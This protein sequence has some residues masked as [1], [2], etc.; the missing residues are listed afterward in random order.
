MS[1][2][3]S[4]PIRALRAGDRFLLPRLDSAYDWYVVT[5]EFDPAAGE[6]RATGQEGVE[7]LDLEPDFEVLV[8]LPDDVDEFTITITPWPSLSG[9]DPAALA[10]QIDQTYGPDLE[11]AVYARDR[12]VDAA[13]RDLIWEQ[14]PIIGSE[15][16]VPREAADRVETLA[17]R[18][19]LLMV[20]LVIALGLQEF[21]ERVPR[22]RKVAKAEM[23]NILA[24]PDL[25]EADQRPEL[26]LTGALIYMSLY[27]EAG[28]PDHLDRASEEIETAM[29][30]LAAIDALWPT[31]NRI[32]AEVLH[33][34]AERLD[35]ADDAWQ[36][37]KL[38]SLLDPYGICSCAP[39]TSA[40]ARALQKSKPGTRVDVVTIASGDVEEFSATLVG[41]NGT[42]VDV[43]TPEGSR[44]LDLRSAQVRPGEL[45]R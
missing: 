23:A 19:M 30:Q 28:D 42:A 33:P 24:V 13:V 7:S 4:V 9:L 25:V 31:A 26:S 40:R 37:D 14:G 45:R 8:E 17:G 6:L 11:E 18:Y 41:M 36:A 10:R 16:G 44:Q 12:R 39:C 5:A 27:D 43:S 22:F 1:Q 3:R 38:R 35:A 2:L 34:I 20:E 15:F 21:F 29:H 32:S